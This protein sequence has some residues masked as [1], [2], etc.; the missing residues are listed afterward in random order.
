MDKFKQ[1]VINKVITKLAS[2]TPEQ[3]AKL[4]AIVKA[5]RRHNPFTLKDDNQMQLGMGSPISAGHHQALIMAVPYGILGGLEGY[6]LSDAPLLGTGV[7]AIGGAALGG[8]LGNVVG[9]V[10][11]TV[12]NTFLEQKIREQEN[13]KA[14]MNQA[15]IGGGLFSDQVFPQVLNI[16]NKT[17]T[18]N[19]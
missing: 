1:D 3:E 6:I 7:G 17:T 16:Y 10:D 14:T 19:K 2:L 12:A 15:G 4:N 18:D 13:L 8:I 11:Q 5:P 9:K